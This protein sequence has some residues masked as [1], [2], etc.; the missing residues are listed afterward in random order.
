MPY[1][2]NAYKF[3]GETW[4][5]E[6]FIISFYLLFSH[7]IFQDTC[8]SWPLDLHI[9]CRDISISPSRPSATLTGTRPSGLETL[10]SAVTEP[11]TGDT[12]DI[13]TQDL[14]GSLED[15]TKQGQVD[16]SL[17]QPTLSFHFLSDE[18]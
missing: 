3:L 6:K 14:N 13:Y 10:P 11:G 7:V 15:S 4:G 17:R 9:N 5:R 16:V 2:T 1:H 8:S 18:N 12:V